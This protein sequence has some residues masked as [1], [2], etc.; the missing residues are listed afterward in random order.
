M[1]TISKAADVVTLINV[2][3]CEPESQQQLIEEWIRATEAALGKPRP[4]FCHCTEA[5]KGPPS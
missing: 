1:I 4:D 5:R 3:T 2:F